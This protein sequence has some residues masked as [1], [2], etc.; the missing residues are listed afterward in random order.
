MARRSWCWA[1]PIGPRSKPTS[2]CC[3]RQGVEILSGQH[4]RRGAVPPGDARRH[5]RLPPGGGDAGRRQA[6]RVLRVDQPRRN[7]A[8]ARGLEETSG[9]SASSTAARSGSTGTERRA[10]PTRGLAARAGQHLRA[11]QGRGRADGPASSTRSARLPFVDPAAG[12][13]VR[14]PRPAAPQ[15]VQG[16]EPGPVSAVRQRAKAAGTWSMWMTWSPAF[17]RACERDEAL[18]RGADRRRAEIRAPCGS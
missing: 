5:P 16:G 14:P 6:G 4:H 17:F 18:G 1:S 8:S 10:S 15:A 3:R 9:S 13:R 2:S 11:D 12:R 7:P